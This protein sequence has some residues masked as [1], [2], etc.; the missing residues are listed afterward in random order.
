MPLFMLAANAV[1][2]NHSVMSCQLQV[3]AVGCDGRFSCGAFLSL[4]HAQGRS[5]FFLSFLQV[6]PCGPAEVL[7]NE[8]LETD[9]QLMQQLLACRMLPRPANNARGP[10]PCSPCL[11]SCVHNVVHLL[12]CSHVFH[13]I[14]AW[15]PTPAMQVGC[16][17]LLPSEIRHATRAWL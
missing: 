4:T 15:L 11:R 9:G 14:H 17:H 5:S 3:T 6:T 8:L 10:D 16:Q 13:A 1:T 7:A 2:A 12:S